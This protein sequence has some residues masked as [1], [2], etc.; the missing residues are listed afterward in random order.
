MATQTTLHRIGDAAEISGPTRLLARARDAEAHLSCLAESAD[1]GVVMHDESDNLTLMNEKFAQLVGVPLQMLAEARTGSRL[2]V[3]LAEQLR[4][5]GAFLERRKELVARP[6]EADRDEL[7]LVRPMRRTLERVSSPVLNDEGEL[8]GRLEI[9]RDVTNQRLLQS[10]LQQTEKMA[11]LGQLISGI[12]HELN[13]P[14]TSIL[15][16][17]QLLLGRRMSLAQAAD[18]R[19]IYQEAERATR[20]V[21]NLLLFARGSQP[22]RRPVNLNDIVE[23]AAALRNYELRLENIGLSLDLD[24]GLP[25]VV[26]DSA[27]LQQ[28][29][30]NLLVNAEQAI[31]QG[32][33]AGGISIRTLRLGH[34]RVGLQ[35]LDTGP[36][37]PAEVMPRIFDPFFTTKP[38]GVGTGLGLSIACSI[39]QDHGGEISVESQPGQ[40]TKFTIELATAKGGVAASS[41][42]PSSRIPAQI[43]AVGPRSERILVVEDEPTVAHLIADVLGEEGHPVE[44]IL[45]ACAGL[46]MA[47]SGQYELVICDLK[48]PRMDGKAFYRELVVKGSHVQNRIV[49]VTGD[50]M[51]PHTMD[52]LESSGL[53]YLAKPFLVE[54]LKSVVAGALHTAS[55]SP[56][57]LNGQTRAGNAKGII[58]HT[59]VEEEFN[60]RSDR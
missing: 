39:I 50:T 13:N 17:A 25:S 6:R 28:V 16:Y 54:E 34:D 14:L 45:D 31:R 51:A 48:M 55:H 36:G 10:K 24:A 46:E 18:A 8:L 7:E 47:L 52:F 58:R 20:I 15:G 59:S 53:P 60:E 1:T 56:L 44:V 19:L 5:P 21:K 49:F 32:N 26:A 41:A 40:G 2:A 33:G 42:Q 11:A 43:I 9:Y 22:E 12:A 35:V 37:I 4:D 23:R 30:L 57:R 29:L 3:I 38:V 27:Q